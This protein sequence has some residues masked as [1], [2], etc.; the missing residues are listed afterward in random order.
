ATACRAG[1]H[2]T[3]SAASPRCTWSSIRT[4]SSPVSRVAGR[5]RR[6]RRSI[7][8]SAA[9]RAFWKPRATATRRGFSAPRGTRSARS[10]SSSRASRRSRQAS[11][12][13]SSTSVRKFGR[14]SGEWLGVRGKD[15]GSPGSGAT[16][17]TEDAATGVETPPGTGQNLRM[18]VLELEQDLAELARLGHV[19]ERGLDLLDRK[20]TVDDA[21]QAPVC[22]RG[23]KMAAEGLHRGGL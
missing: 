23:Q 11:L 8:S 22:E 21:A 2:W 10:R 7:Q 13:R 17:A 3:S 20:D 19:V 16:G 15:A 12:S 6:R 1:T 5:S 18:G 4:S 14:L 9:L